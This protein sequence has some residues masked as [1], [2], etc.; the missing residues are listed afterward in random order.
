MNKK[1]LIGVGIILVIAAIFIRKYY[2]TEFNYVGTVEATRID[3]S[4]RLAANIEKYNFQ[5]GDLVKENDLLVTLDCKDIGISRDY[6]TKT[7][8][9][10]EKLLKSGSLP[11]EAFDLVLKNKQEIDLKWSWCK[12]SSPIAGTILTNFMDDKEWVV[13]GTKLTSISDL[14]NIWTYIYVEQP[15]LSQLEIG[16]EVEGFI[17]ELSEKKFQG[18]IIKINSEAEFTPK[19]VQTREERSRLVFG[20]KIQFENRNKVLKPGMSIEVKLPKTKD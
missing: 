7:Y 16:T 8:D 12:I 3:L 6:A 15:M 20:I 5:E 4:S 17:P 1:A 14:T 10:S 11:K 18:K 13:P 2:F 19:N 9:R